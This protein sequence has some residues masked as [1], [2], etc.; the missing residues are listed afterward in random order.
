[1]FFEQQYLNV[2]VVWLGGGLLGLALRYLIFIGSTALADVPDKSLGFTALIVAP[3]W[4]VG[5]PVGLVLD[6]FLFQRPDL[7][8]QVPLLRSMPFL[9]SYAH[10]GVP[11][12]VGLAVTVVALG[13]L[14]LPVYTQVLGDSKKGVKTAIFEIGLNLLAAALITMAVFFVLAIFQVAR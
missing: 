14:A 4:L 12:F 8:K 9:T 6:R 7:F 10:L 3:L 1:M 11:R 2:L 5:F 13:L